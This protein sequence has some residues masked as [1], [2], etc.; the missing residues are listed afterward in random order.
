MRS[1]TS[2]PGAGPTEPVP[3]PVGGGAFLLLAHPARNRRMLPPLPGDWD[4]LPQGVGR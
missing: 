2:L 3:A 1:L 4:E